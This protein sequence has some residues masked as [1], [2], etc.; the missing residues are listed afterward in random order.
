MRPRC[1]QVHPESLGSTAGFN[2]GRWGAHNSVRPWARVLHPGS[3]RSMGFAL[4]VVGL[5]RGPP[6]ASSVVRGRRSAA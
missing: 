1:R 4:G 3:L 5:N 6:W 2:T